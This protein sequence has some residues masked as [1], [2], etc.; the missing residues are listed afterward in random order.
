MDK[1]NVSMSKSYGK[2]INAQFNSYNSHSSAALSPNYLEKGSDS[3]IENVF[4]DAKETYNS[5]KNTVSNWWDDVTETVDGWFD[6]VGANVSPNVKSLIEE[7]SSWWDDVTDWW[8]SDFSPWVKEAAS[9]VWDDIKSAGAT[10][11][12]GVQS[13]VEGILEFG[14]SIV[15]FGALL[16]TG[17][18]SIGTG[19]YDGY[20]A[21]RGAI[22]DEEWSSVT[23]QMWNG[24]KGFVSNQYV[25]GWFDSLYQNTGYGQWL[26]ENAIA[27]DS[28]RDVA[29]G[30]GYV[31]GVVVLSVATFGAGS[32][33]ATGGTAT[34]ASAMAATT[35]AQMAATAAVAGI[36][37]GTQNAWADGAGILEGLGA[38]TLSGIWEGCQFYVGGK[39]GSLN[40][41]GADGVLKSVGS[42]EIGT[43][44]LNGLSRV[45]LD[46]IDGGVEG[47]VAPIISSIYKDGYYDESGNYIEFSDEQNIFDRYSEMFDDN[48]G[49]KNVLTQASVGSFTSLLGEAFDLGKHFSKKPEADVSID[50]K[51]ETDVP[52]INISEQ[53]LQSKIDTYNELLK[54]RESDEYLEYVDRGLKGYAGSLKPEFYKLEER[55]AQLQNELS[56]YGTILSK[57]ED[58]VNIRNEATSKVGISSLNNSVLD[59]TT[60]NNLFSGMKAQDAKYGDGT[61]IAALY[62]YL[63]E[64][65]IIDHF[66]RDGGF[67]SL[68]ESLP[69]EQL[70]E[71]YNKVPSKEAKLFDYMKR[72]DREVHPVG[73]SISKDAVNKLKTYDDLI[74]SAGDSSLDFQSKMDIYNKLLDI[75]NSDEYLIYM[76]RVQSGKS[77]PLNSEF[78]NLEGRIAQLQKELSE[79]GNDM[80]ANNLF[81]NSGV[82]KSI[83]N[84]VNEVEKSKEKLKTVS[85]LLVDFYEDAKDLG[86]K[87]DV[88]LGYEEHNFVHVTR[89]ADTSVSVLEQLNKMINDGT[90]KDFKT[91]DSDIIYKAGLA[92]DL[93]MKDGGYSK[94]KLTPDGNFMKDKDGNKIL[95]KTFEKIPDN[96]NGNVIRTNHSLNSAITVL[97]NKEL[98]GDDSEMI[99]CL[100]FI[101]SKS[102]SGVKDILDT[103]ELASMIKCLY[104]NAEECGY[105]FDINKFGHMDNL[106]QFVFNDGVAEQMRTGAVALRV[107]DAHAAKTGF[108]HGGGKLEIEKLPDS[109]VTTQN[110]KQDISKLCEL[111]ASDAKINVNYNDSTIPLEGGSYDFSKRVVL[112]E[113][114]VITLDSRVENGTLIHTH[115]VKT[116]SNPACSWVFGIK[117]KLGEY[118]TFSAVP[119]KVEIQ[120]P[121]D[122]S[123]DLYLY[124]QEF[125]NQ[126]LD[127]QKSNGIKEIVLK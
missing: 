9:V 88:F 45:V 98:F 41:F 68:V 80:N 21:I 57:T 77:I 35:S 63:Y 30:I 5:V 67:R 59:E 19:I 55:I 83:Y 79:Y 27:F 4:D 39:I 66:S 1:I 29:S 28:V 47:F 24:T 17:I 85:P 33:V 12:V 49:W 60:Y 108:N 123:P 16:G 2:E 102:T 20:Q 114:N 76:Q 6:D 91:I 124:Y 62:N 90:L 78:S 120:L 94:Y 37:K 116:E 50:N 97:Q 42:S 112:G 122:A 84:Y 93:G 51:L 115:V 73:S 118:E 64:N 71:F 34:A 104:D 70:E 11:A 52:K 3:F 43:K 75:R 82:N 99:A 92:H 95:V 89:V 100:A 54:I 101:H 107:G 7:A 117:E 113:R 22:T 8:N 56:M 125:I 72:E 109:V 110:F 23:K 81:D 10:I 69:R 25:S 15:D 126:Y 53:E 26:S 106:G 103:N 46:G 13:L 44:I 40:L 31:S 111:E 48:G 96:A 61:A 38:G 32:V 18:A 65:G 74:K 14:E 58:A 127:Q 119:Q 121:S 105:K 86:V 87:N 36:G